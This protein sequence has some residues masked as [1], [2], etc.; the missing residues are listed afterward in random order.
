MFLGFRIDMKSKILEHIQTLCQHY[1]I[2]SLYVFGS[3]AKEVFQYVHGSSRM[4]DRKGVDVDVGVLPAKYYVLNPKERIRL[5]ID[6]EDLL[7]V[8]S[9]DLVVLSE[10]SPFLA[11]EVIKG[12]LLYTADPDQTA[13]YEL[14]VLRVAGDL[15][16]FEYQR[17]GQLLKY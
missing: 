11:L 7:E 3:Q 16:Y 2:D 15:A 14:Y 4:S 5:T 8:C 13:E 12:E 6:M 1:Q 9:V 10:I 17:R